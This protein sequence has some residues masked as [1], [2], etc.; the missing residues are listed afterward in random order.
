[1]TANSLA[2]TKKLVVVQYVLQEEIINIKYPSNQYIMMPFSRRHQLSLLLLPLLLERCLCFL[3][4]FSCF[5]RLLL[6]SLLPFLLRFF[7][8]AFLCASGGNSSAGGKALKSKPALCNMASASRSCK[9]RQEQS[10]AAVSLCY[11]LLLQQQ[12]KTGPMGMQVQNRR[13]PSCRCLIRAGPS[14]L[15]SKRFFLISI[16]F[17]AENALAAWQLKGNSSEMQPGARTL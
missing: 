12:H 4:F 3:C 6:F 5:A 11:P 8:E 7:L 17:V 10:K 1:M 15:H 16:Q 9:C 14:T 13:A 2:H